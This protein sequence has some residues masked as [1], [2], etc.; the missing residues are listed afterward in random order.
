MAICQQIGLYDDFL[1][2]HALHRMSPMI[3]LWS[4]VFYDDP[5]SFHQ[6]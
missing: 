6:R 5:T 4:Y 1:T 3:D 2:H